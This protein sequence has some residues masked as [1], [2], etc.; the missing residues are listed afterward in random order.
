VVQWVNFELFDVKVMIVASRRI[1]I[2]I[3]KRSSSLIKLKQN[4]VA[5]HGTLASA[6]GGKEATQDGLKR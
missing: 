5:S 4:S 6:T 1:D 2:C 3:I